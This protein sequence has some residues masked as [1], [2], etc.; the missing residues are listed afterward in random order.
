SRTRFGYSNILATPNIFRP[1]KPDSRIFLQGFRAY[2]SPDRARSP[3]HARFIYRVGHLFSVGFLVLIPANSLI[4][5]LGTTVV[6]RHYR[7][8]LQIWSVLLQSRRQILNRV[9]VGVDVCR[10]T[11]GVIS[12]NGLNNPLGPHHGSQGDLVGRLNNPLWITKP[13][14]LVYQNVLSGE[15]NHHSVVRVLVVFHLVPVLTVF[16]YHRHFFGSKR[17]EPYSSDEV[18]GVDGVDSLGHA[19]EF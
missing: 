5:R 18:P 8:A 13:C 19:S 14:H 2:C 17:G 12:P 16:I 15:L 3:L 7:S 11:H 1:L 9:L 4:R 10:V 6:T